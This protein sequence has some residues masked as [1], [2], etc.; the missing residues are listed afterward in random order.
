MNGGQQARLR[1]IDC[2]LQH[3]GSLNRSVLEDYWGLSTP[4]VSIDIREYTKAAPLNLVYDK[5]RKTYVRTS[6]FKRAFP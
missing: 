4:Q 1:F 2:M 6:E 5:S 3:Y